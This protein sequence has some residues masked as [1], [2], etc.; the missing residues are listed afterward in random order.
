[1]YNLILKDILI[2]KK[3]FLFTLLYVPFMAIAFQGSGAGMVTIGVVGATY[4]LITTACAHDDKSNSNIILNSLPIKRN[5]IVISKYMSIY[6]YGIIG[7]LEYYFISKIVNVIGLDFK[8]YP[9]TLEG[10][11]AILVTITLINSIYFPVFFKVG[12]MK[13]RVINILMFVGLFVGGSYLSSLLYNNEISNELITK[14][15][16]FINS[17]SEFII[18]TAMIGLMIFIQLI[19]ISISIKIY[20][21]R[22]F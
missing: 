16:S 4:M 7:G 15:I 10:I 1:M 11:I 3:T 13:S 6:F 19:S 22:E 18:I 14:I 8:F 20:N 2:L 5:R 17:K 21:D 12:Y 9:I